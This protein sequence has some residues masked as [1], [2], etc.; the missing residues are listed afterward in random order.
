MDA[1][2]WRKRI[3]MTRLARWLLSVLLG[4]GILMWFWIAGAA[5][6]NYLYTEGFPRQP[7][8]RFLVGEVVILAG[9]AAVIIAL[10]LL[11]GATASRVLSWLAIVAALAQLVFFGSALNLVLRG[12]GWRQLQSTG[13]RRLLGDLALFQ[14]FRDHAAAAA[15]LVVFAVIAA[16]IGIAAFTLVSRHRGRRI[17]RVARNS[18]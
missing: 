3:C 13:W 17:A 18:C 7:L 2:D 11:W 1:G 16:I 12:L 4:I 14:L 10:T 15:A 5:L 6:A 8:P 9:L